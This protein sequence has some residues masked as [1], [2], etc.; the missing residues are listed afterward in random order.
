[1]SRKVLTQ[2]TALK[3]DA[4]AELF[5]RANSCPVLGKLDDEQLSQAIKYISKS[6]CVITGLKLLPGDTQPMLSLMKRMIPAHYGRLTHDEIVYAFELNSM[7]K[8]SGVADVGS[9]NGVIHHFQS[10]NMDYIGK[11]LSAYMVYRKG[12]AS[13][14]REFYNA[15]EYSENQKLLCG[16][17]ARPDLDDEQLIAESLNDFQQTGRVYIA[18]TIYEVLVKLHKIS[19]DRYFKFRKK[20][21]QKLIGEKAR[22]QMNTSRKGTAISIGKAIEQLKIENLERPAEGSRTSDPVD[23]VARELAV[24]D[25]MKTFLNQADKR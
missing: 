14:I 2:L 3:Y 16:E 6:I 5:R 25:W 10:F 11:V 7:G 8:F 17:V 24:I 9:E 13:T 15:V 18:G 20:A 4:A 1:M 21:R 23:T 19:P 22:E 12:F